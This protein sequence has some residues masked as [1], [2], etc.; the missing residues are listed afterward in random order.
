MVGNGNSQ[1]G[2]PAG[3]P[4][5]SAAA[6][7][8]ARFQASARVLWLIAVGSVGDRARAEDVV[9]EAAIVALGKLEQFQAGT[10][11]TAWMG[12]IVR[13]V[14][15]NHARKEQKA[16]LVHDRE[17]LEQ[18]IRSDRSNGQSGELRLTRRGELPP[19]QEWFDDR[20][21]RALKAVAE[22]PR[23]CLLLRTVEGLEYSEIARLLGI[24][25]GTAMSHVH[26]TRRMLR[27][28]LAAM[29]PGGGRAKDTQE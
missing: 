5:S 7:F 29:Q 2:A 21:V 28:R 19:D 8:A 25:E 9:Q 4:S 18:S 17:A 6:D 10:N 20:V 1:S 24:P 23:A 16:S 14:A 13:F 11:F 27:E 22:I 15:L 26:R 12:Q 3:R